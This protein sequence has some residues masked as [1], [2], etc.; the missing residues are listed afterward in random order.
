MYY[1]IQ[2]QQN[3]MRSSSILDRRMNYLTGTNMYLVERGRAASVSKKEKK[4]RRPAEEEEPGND[5]VDKDSLVSDGMGP[6][7][8]ERG[9]TF[10]ADYSRYY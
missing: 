4:E 3:E 6:V 1:K 5:W 7:Y 9:K 10:L 8:G 2:T